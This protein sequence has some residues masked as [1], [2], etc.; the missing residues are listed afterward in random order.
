MSIHWV[1]KENRNLRMS[2]FTVTI[3]ESNVFSSSSSRLS[4]SSTRII[5]SWLR[6]CYKMLYKTYHLFCIWHQPA[7]DDASRLV[8]I[9]AIFVLNLIQVY[10]LIINYKIFKTHIGSEYIQDR[11]SNNKRSQLE[12]VANLQFE[13]NSIYRHVRG[14]LSH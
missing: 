12:Q 10:Y 7:L 9:C 14:D 6:S 1:K 11:I 3:S 8:Y 2:L 13:C 5:I 4:I